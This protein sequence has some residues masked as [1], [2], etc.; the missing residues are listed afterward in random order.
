M[1]NL[2]APVSSNMD[3]ARVTELRGELMKSKLLLLLALGATLSGYGLAQDA[4][5][6][7]SGPAPAAGTP[8][9]DKPATSAPATPPI[10]ILQGEARR[11]RPLRQRRKATASQPK[12]RPSLPIPRTRKKRKTSS[13]FRTTARPTMSPPSATAMWDAARAWETGIHWRPRSSSAR[14]IRCR[15]SR[16][17]A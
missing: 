17:P 11:R 15:S 3:R 2:T 6:A 8:A 7:P 13:T 5:G 9:A 14:A 10:P 1:C 4:G 16:A 12:P